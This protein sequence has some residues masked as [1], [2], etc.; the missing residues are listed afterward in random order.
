MNVA[1]GEDQRCGVGIPVS[2]KT[3]QGRLSRSVRGGYYTIEQVFVG[4]N[5]AMSFTADSLV[6]RSFADQQALF[7]AARDV[8]RL[9]ERQEDLD[10]NLALALKRMLIA[11][12]EQSRTIKVVLEE[13]SSASGPKEGPERPLALSSQ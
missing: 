6:E 2:D 3:G 11:I 1:R 7:S 9:A 4:G 5:A 13:A 12:A 8:A 10:D